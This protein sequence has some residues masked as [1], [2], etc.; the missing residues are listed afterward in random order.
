VSQAGRT[1]FD[2]TIEKTNKVLKDIEESYGWPR[3]RRKESYDAL[4]AV[5]HALRDRLV[6]TEAADMA[7]QLPTLIR[8]L[9]YEGWKPAK[10]P[11]KMTREEFLGRVRREFPF[12]VEGGPGLLVERVVQA[13][14]RYVTEGEWE[15]I[16]STLP[17]ELAEILPA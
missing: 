8:G 2:V 1:P 5:L 7:A 17:R 4:R 3:E 15:D 9:F 6:V 13:I 14:R 12:E 10:V 11:V 16:R